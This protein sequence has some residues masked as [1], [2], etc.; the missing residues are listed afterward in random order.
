MATAT[1][2]PA[3]KPAAGKQ[4]AAQ[5]PLRPFLVGTLDLETHTYQS[6]GTL[7]TGQVEQPTFNIK[8]NG[9]LCDLWLHV[10]ATAAGNSAAVAFNE[11]YPLKAVAT[12][13]LADTGGQMILGPMTGWELAMFVKWGGFSFSDDVLDSQTYSAVT[14]TGATG[15]SFGFILHI[16]IQFISK[17]P[18]GPFPNTNSNTAF[19]IDF[20]IDTLAHIYSVAPTAAP[21]YVT[22]IYQDSY[23]QSAG[24]DA[25]GGVSSKTPVALG[26]TLFLRRNTKELNAGGVDTEIDFPA[27]SYRALMFCLRDSTGSRAQGDADWMDPMAVFINNDVP[28]DRYKAQWLR[29]QE[30]AFGYTAA[31]NTVNGR[32]N[33]LFTLPFNTD[34]ELKAGG[35]DRYKYLSLSAADTVGYRGTIG[36]SGTH[37]MTNMFNYVRPPGGKIKAL[38]P[39]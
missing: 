20:T 9:F 34:G 38:T 17:L 31:V 37:V 3:A 8:T 39:K 12:F 4:A 22:R 14:G 10:I 18:M 29:R 25:Q 32:N 35:E 33:G 27:G 2:Q 13:Q 6:S 5:P 7:G 1:A 21:T 23:R 28:Y 15:G 36:G 24:K 30:R 16:P 11:D 19:M 26:A